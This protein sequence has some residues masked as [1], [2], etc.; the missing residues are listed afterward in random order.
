MNL[1]FTKLVE[2]SPNRNTQK[3]FLLYWTLF[4]IISILIG[5]YTSCD[6]QISD[7]QKGSCNVVLLTAGQNIP[8]RSNETIFITPLVDL[9]WDGRN[10]LKYNCYSN[11]TFIKVDII[12]SITANINFLGDFIC[13]GKHWMKLSD[14]TLTNSPTWM[15]SIIDESYVELNKNF[16]NPFTILFDIKNEI[17]T[18]FTIY[19]EVNVTFNKNIFNTISQY[20]N[21]VNN[22]DVVTSY[23]CRSCYGHMD[24]FD[25]QSFIRLIITMGTFFSLATL[26]S[27]KII[28][29][30]LNYQY[31]ELTP[32]K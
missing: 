27:T 22:L 3:I 32:S 18:V 15:Q 26:I 9:F 17:Q 11:I 10:G 23:Q 7:Y 16:T 21:A 2:L 30:F 1:Q 14:T 20:T 28:P 29:K 12:N 19:D 4:L 24:T 8:M 13:N 25:F 31:D 6:Y 5:L